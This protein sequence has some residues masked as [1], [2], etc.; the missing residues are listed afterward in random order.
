MIILVGFC[1]KFKSGK[2]E[3]HDK[4]IKGKKNKKKKEKMLHRERAPPM[5]E[6]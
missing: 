2:N 3:E 6:D 4:K 1:W 5:L